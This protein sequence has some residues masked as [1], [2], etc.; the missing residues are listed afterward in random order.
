M[1]HQHFLYFI[2]EFDLVRPEELQPL[3]PLI[4][5]L[6]KVRMSRYIHSDTTPIVAHMQLLLWQE[7]DLKW[8]P[9][10]PINGRG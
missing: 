10:V 4:D 1:P 3:K 9:K 2:L 5:K 8:G 7:D 6:I